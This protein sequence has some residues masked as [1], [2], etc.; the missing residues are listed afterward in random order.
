[1]I[2]GSKTVVISL[3]YRIEISTDRFLFTSRNPSSGDVVVW[4][5]CL[6]AAVSVIYGIIMKQSFVKYR[7]GDT[8]EATQTI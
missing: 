8:R 6:P 3:F 2:L 5:L 7:V 1:M 4:L